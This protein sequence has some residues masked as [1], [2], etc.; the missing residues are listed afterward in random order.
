MAIMAET[1]TKLAA[2]SVS[3]AT[4]ATESEVGQ[5]RE[6]VQSLTDHLRSHLPTSYTVGLRSYCQANR[7]TTP[8]N[9]STASNSFS[10]DLLS[11]FDSYSDKI[12]GFLS[13]NVKKA[14]KAY[15]R[16]SHFAILAYIIGTAATALAIVSKATWII[17]YWGNIAPPPSVVSRWLELLTLFVSSVSLTTVK[18]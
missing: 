1:A 6:H 10:F 16:T 15:D 5:A 18:I 8:S 12:D 4:S 14:L 9:C 11:L 7:G 3:Q 2:N 13:G 17:F